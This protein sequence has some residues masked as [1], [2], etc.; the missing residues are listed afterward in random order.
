LNP[1]NG[2]EG[3]PEDRRQRSHV[4][5]LITPPS[6]AIPALAVAR[7]RFP[8]ENTPQTLS[9]DTAQTF[10][11]DPAKLDLAAKLIACAPQGN[12]ARLMKVSLLRRA[13]LEGTY[14]VSAEYLAAKLI[15]DLKM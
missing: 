2:L 3:C 13:I 7:R 6:P 11:G 12:D 1:I 5:G 8:D 9:Y 10:A 4:A 14:R 15:A